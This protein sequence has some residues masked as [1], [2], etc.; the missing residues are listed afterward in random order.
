MVNFLP[1]AWRREAFLLDSQAQCLC[2]QYERL[3]HG[4]AVGY[5]TYALH[6]LYWFF[7]G[8]WDPVCICE[9]LGPVWTCA[10]F[11]LLNL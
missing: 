11:A 6:I 10:L 1:G 8:I 2:L 9:K 3:P 4:L 7:H 5:E